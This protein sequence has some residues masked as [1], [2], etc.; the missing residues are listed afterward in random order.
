MMI[1]MGF[2]ALIKMYVKELKCMHFK[3]F[4][5]RVFCCVLYGVVNSSPTAGTTEE[6][7]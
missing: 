2:F 4:R 1:Y 6:S 3:C 7:L 5:F